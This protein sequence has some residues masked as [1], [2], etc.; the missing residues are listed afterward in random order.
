MTDEKSTNGPS[1]RITVRLRGALRDNYQRS[2]LGA[3]DWLENLFRI[4]QN[5]LKQ[6]PVTLTDA[7]RQVLEKCVG[8][9]VLNET[10]VKYLSSRVN[11]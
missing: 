2:G 4:Y 10:I 6:D 5:M 9:S 11:V 1:I 7:E 8:D 3:T